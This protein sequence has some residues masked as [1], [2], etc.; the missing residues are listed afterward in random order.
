MKL[1]PDGNM[2][3]EIVLET[4]KLSGLLT[5][6]GDSVAASAG[7]NSARWKILG[8]IYLSSHSL[9]VPQIARTM[10]QSRQAVQ[11]LVD[12]MHKD[13]LLTFSDNPNHKKAKLIALTEKGSAIYLKVDEQQ[14][15]WANDLADNLDAK[16]LAIT[17]QTLKKIQQVLDAK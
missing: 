9:T 16:D 5:T 14:I 1:S 17:L 7:I 3:T 6:V 2:F 8:A 15:P 4:F 11:R 10:G 13:N 12:I